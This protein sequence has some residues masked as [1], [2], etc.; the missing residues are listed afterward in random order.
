[1]TYIV[2]TMAS[3]HY[4]GTMALVH[5]VA[6]VAFDHIVGTMTFDRIIAKMT[7]DNT[8]AFNTIVIIFTALV[9]L[10]TLSAVM[11]RKEHAWHLSVL[12]YTFSILFPFGMINMILR[13]G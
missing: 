1:M 8:V 7:S 9:A 13:Y 4:V 11:W 5:N 2:A 6:I 12:K 3:D 10:V